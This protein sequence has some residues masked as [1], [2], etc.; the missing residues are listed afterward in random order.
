MKISHSHLKEVSRNIL[1]AIGA[2]EGEVDVVSRSLLMADLR[3]IHTHGINFLPKVVSRVEN[4]V[5]QIPTELEIISDEGS[6]THID[7]HNGF[8][9]VAAERGMRYAIEHGK[10]HGIGLSLIRNTNHIGLLAFYS[11]MAAEEGMVGFVMTN[12]APCMAP[13][14]GAEPFFGTN[15]F[16]VAAPSGEEYPII[17]DM[18]TSLVARG[19]IRRA[20][21]LDKE[22]PEDWALDAEGKKTTDPVKALEGTLLPMGG[23]KGYGMAFF[24]DLICGLLSGS[25]FSR[26]I[27]TFHKPLGPTGVGTMVVAIDIERFMDM[28][29]FS[30]LVKDHADAIRSSK[31]AEGTERVFLPGEIELEAERRGIREGVEVDEPT[32]K[33]LNTLLEKYEIALRM[34]GA[35]S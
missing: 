7:G 20:V 5:M 4:G 3:G 24:I 10:K 32:I 6:A 16:S 2:A 25:R 31:K 15:P 8:G 18:S 17:L 14:G 34:D 12:S 27:L 13:W 29:T 19:K 1:Q 21:R 30:R 35:D 23:P 26:D 33:E 28:S 22:I 11:L 9:Q